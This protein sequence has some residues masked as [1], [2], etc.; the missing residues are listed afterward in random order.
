MN[1]DGDV[2]VWGENTHG[3]LGVGLDKPYSSVPIK[4]SKFTNLSYGKVTKVYCTEN[5]THA[6]LKFN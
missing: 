3:Q 6:I 5:S 4:I 2:Y 1:E